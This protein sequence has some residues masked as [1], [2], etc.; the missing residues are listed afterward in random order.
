MMVPPKDR[1]PHV[2]V[3]NPWVRA[4]V[5]AQRLVRAVQPVA[6]RLRSPS[7]HLHSREAAAAAAVQVRRLPP[8]LHRVGRSR[9]R[10]AHLLNRCPRH[11]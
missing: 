9:P 1:P 8:Y 10:C 6:A 3:A 7:A 5:A 11:S 4:L 2:R